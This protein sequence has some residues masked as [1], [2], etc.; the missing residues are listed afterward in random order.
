M[1]V[2]EEVLKALEENRGSYFSG[3][4][5][6]ERLNKSRAA[7]WKAIKQLQSEGY[8]IEAVTNKGYSLNVSTDVLSK[9]GI[10][11]YIDHKYK[12]NDIIVYKTI[13][14]TNEQAKKEAMSGAREGT[15][16][17]AEEQTAGKGRRGR[18][19][20][21]PYGTG[22]YMSIILRPDMEMSEATFITTA[23]SVA[24][25]RVIESV[26]NQ[27]A[28]I[29]WVN[30]IYIDGKKAAGIL[31][32][33]VMDFETEKVDWVIVGIGLNYTTEESSYPEDI[34]DIATSVFEGKNTNVTRNELAA[35]IINEV[36][37]ICTEKSGGKF[38]EEY[39][40][41]SIVIGNNIAV[42]R[43]GK[44]ECA[45]AI[46]IDNSGGLVV[47]YPDGRR[48]TL[49]SGEITIRLD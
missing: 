5:L 31:T 45:K 34:K 7:I 23:V 46:D 10:G 47:E 26:T 39:K 4:V 29:K 25:A 6:A 32:E 48:D 14:S 44:S 30:D 13:G 2:K 43:D 16:I 3:Q 1:T 49:K 24:V 27:K 28:G 33:A 37:D 40:E 17:I 42:I 8:M 19:F 41:R 21:S 18:S 15:V 22:I 36:L 9:E 38:I 20:F 12:A 35:K 11:Q